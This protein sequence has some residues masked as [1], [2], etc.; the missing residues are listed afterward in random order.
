MAKDATPKIGLRSS[1]KRTLRFGLV[2]VG[3]SMAPALDEDARVSARLLD[4]D[5]LTPLSQVYLNGKGE[6]VAHKDRVKGYAYGDGFVTL[7]EDEVPKASST[8]LIELAANVA[9]ADIPAEWI[10]KTYLAWPTDTTQD[11]GYALVSHYLHHYDRAFVGTTVAN[12]TTKVLVIRWS[13]TYECVVAQLLNYAAQVR[14]DNLAILHAGLAAI[15]A[16]D[17]SMAD[18]ASTVFES[19]TDTFDWSTVRDEYGEALAAAVVEKGESGTV[20]AAP[21][22]AT[23]AAPADLMAALQASVPAAKA[24]KAKKGSKVTA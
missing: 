16:P 11:A 19:L 22:T 9:S 5:S 14:T 17:E 24:A 23:T 20:T 4:P 1:Q 7:S 18:M 13:H 21:S 6:Q 10:D 2:N 15:P 3:I 12:G 8:D